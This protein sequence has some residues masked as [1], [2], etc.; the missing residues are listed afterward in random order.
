MPEISSP[1]HS[2]I[3]ARAYHIW[4]REGRPHGRD[5]DHWLAAERELRGG[6]SVASVRRARAS[7]TRPAAVKTKPVTKSN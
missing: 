7:R 5:L 1:K 2:E 3:A 4:E 6:G